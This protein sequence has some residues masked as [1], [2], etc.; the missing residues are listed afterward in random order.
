[1]DVGV[2]CVSCA[3]ARVPERE[4]GRGGGGAASVRTECTGLPGVVC[5]GPAGGSVHHCR[6]DSVQGARRGAGGSG[7][8]GAPKAAAPQPP[9]SARPAPVPSQAELRWGTGWKRE[10]P[11]NNVVLFVSVPKA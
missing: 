3:R 4:A 11:R 6:R 2:C 5:A 7:R 10:G 1:M 9:H 8:A